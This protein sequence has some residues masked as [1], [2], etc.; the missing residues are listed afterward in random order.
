MARNQITPRQLSRSR[1]EACTST[2]SRFHGSD[3]TNSRPRTGRDAMNQSSSRRVDLRRHRT[4]KGRVPGY[5]LMCSG[6]LVC[7]SMTKA[8]R[9]WASAA[10]QK[11]SHL[12]PSQPTIETWE[13]AVQTEMDRPIKWLLPALILAEIAV[14]G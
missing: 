7:L 8:M 10:W 11:L 5:L 4:I 9:R 12:V 1:S 3:V 2:T 13:H 6:H 14:I